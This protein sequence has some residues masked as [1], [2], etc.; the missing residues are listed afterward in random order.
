MTIDQIISWVDM[1]TSS[2]SR[3]HE[4]FSYRLSEF[5]DGILNIVGPDTWIGEFLE[6]LFSDVFPNVTLIEILLVLLSLYLLLGLCSNTLL[7]L[8]LLQA[9]DICIILCYNMLSD[10]ERGVYYAF[11]WFAF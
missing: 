11:D 3:F 1:I 7:I 2:F 8:F 6:L 9:L 10:Y 4:I 5:F